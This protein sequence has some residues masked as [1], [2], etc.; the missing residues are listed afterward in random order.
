ME[1]PRGSLVGLVLA[2]GCANARPPNHGSRGLIYKSQR[3]EAREN[4][5]RGHEH[6][7]SRLATERQEL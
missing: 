5:K 3:S 1:A 6:N 4:E 2:W 7:G